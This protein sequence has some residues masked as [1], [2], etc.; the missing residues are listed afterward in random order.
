MQKTNGGTGEQSLQQYYI[1]SATCPCQES[2]R[3]QSEML[4]MGDEWGDACTANSIA[5]SKKHF[6]K[7]ANHMLGLALIAYVRHSGP[8]SMRQ[9]AQGE[10]SESTVETYEVQQPN[11]PSIPIVLFWVMS[12]L[13]TSQ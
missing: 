13:S 1:R 4:E 5:L 3:K 12:A 8:I 7:D 11:A 6:S 9:L 2:K 10:T